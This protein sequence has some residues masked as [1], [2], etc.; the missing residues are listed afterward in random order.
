[1]STPQN[2]VCRYGPTPS[3][4]LHV[5]SARTALFIY[6]FA[7]S[8]GGEFV[9]RIDDTDVAAANYV[10]TEE[11]IESL[12]W[13][14]IK[15]DIGPIYQSSRFDIYKQYI[16]QL[17][18]TGHAYREESDRGVAVRFRVGNNKSEFVDLIHGPVR[19]DMS[20]YEDFVIQRS[21]GDPT[22][23][24]ATVVD[25]HLMGIT[26]LPRGNDLFSCTHQQ[27]ALYSALGWELP[28]YAHIPLVNGADGK[29][30]SKRHGD[31]SVLDFRDNLY[32]PEALLNYLSM[33][34]WS[35]GNNREILSLSEMEECFDFR[36]IGKKNVVFDIPKLKWVNR[37]YLKKSDLTDLSKT[38]FDL[39][40]IRE[41]VDRDFDQS[42]LLDIVKLFTPRYYSNCD[43]FVWN[44]IYFYNDEIDY[45]LTEVDLIDRALLL[46]I[47]DAL[48]SVGCFTYSD[49]DKTMRN[50][51]ADNG[52]TFSDLVRSLRFVVTGRK[53]TPDIV[54][55]MLIIG[56]QGVLERIAGFLENHAG[57]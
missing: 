52:L 43:E 4:R 47:K 3:G 33:L 22:Y 18:D 16:Q 40:L 10:Y 53:V 25:D 29:K 57:G 55:V 2:M 41:V 51:A 42:K 8:Q 26:C 50:F 1:M 35:P 46:G 31:T 56:R 49:V 6:L 37:Q 7:K 13:L 27:N 30:L 5:G 11:A 15:W 34:G 20:R 24:I 17:I 39:L 48:K 12:Q 28:R 21:N 19:E 23:Q 9:L 36:K 32:L 14:G 44:T 54:S 45:D 38:L